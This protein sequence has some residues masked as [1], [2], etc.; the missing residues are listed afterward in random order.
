M[1]VGAD[2]IG[3]GVTTAGDAR[4]TPIGRFLRRTKLDEL[5]QLLN[6]L[7][8]EMSL[9]GPRPEDPRYV[10]LYNDEQREVLHARPGITSPAS[11][12]Y[13]HEEAA[14]SGTDWETTYINQV[15]PDKLAIDL[16]YVRRA[17]VLQD[18]AVLW[19]TVRAVL[20]FSA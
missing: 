13:R 7:R 6:V 5:P 4:I 19:R 11:V 15:M 3:P 20:K 1:V 18:I 14:L 12:V 9:V 10:R 8:G 2:R 16:A 17:G